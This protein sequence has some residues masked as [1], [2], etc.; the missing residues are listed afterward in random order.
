MSGGPTQVEGPA[1]PEPESGP[2]LPEWSWTA[3]SGAPV[4]TTAPS[5]EWDVAGTPPGAPPAAPSPE[6]DVSVGEPA[7]GRATGPRSKPAGGSGWEAAAAPEPP[8]RAMEPP[9]DGTAERIVQ[10]TPPMKPEGVSGRIRNGQYYAYDWGFEQQQYYERLA[11]QIITFMISDS[12]LAA[13]SARFIL[14]R[15]AGVDRGQRRELEY[16]LKPHFPSMQ[17]TL[18]FDDLER[19]LDIVYDELIG[20]GPLGTAWRDDEVTEIMVDG[21]N[22][23]YVEH[24]GQLIISTAKFRSPE[25]ANQIARNL[26]QMVSDRSLSP[27]NPLVTAELDG[28]RVNFAYAPVVKSGLAITL[29]KFMP[30]MGMQSLLTIGSLSEDMA[31]F[32]RDAVVARSTLLVSGGTGVGKTTLINALS[33]FIPN[34][35]RVITI[36]DA[37]ELKLANLFVLPLQTK[38][39]AS[40]D[41]DVILTQEDLLVNT[42]RMRPDRIVVGEIRDARAAT[43][44]L[45]AANTG[46]D[47]TMTTIHA[48]SA[49]AALNGRLASLIR[50]GSGVSDDIAK[51]QIAEA[52]DVVLQGTRRRGRRFVEEIAEVG[53]EGFT[54][55]LIKPRPIFRAAQ[56]PDGGVSFTRVGGIDPRGSLAEKMR[57]AGI[58]PARWEA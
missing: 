6:G 26:A 48:N 4:S 22:R 36:E 16:E 15:D 19:V 18:A 21:W 27:T 10:P 11:D 40:R 53:T 3:P 45:Q 30:L 2:E 38:E 31:S 58:D 8:G 5:P 13:L 43:V 34:S 24:R 12:Q 39:R 29:R 14:T 1:R 20:L 44:M 56:S 55:S 7:Q 33:E 46:H 23:V 42:L 52:F 51:Y 47:G 17:L 57:E 41:D 54:G 35:E 9:A 49:D 50:T 28:A 25:H 32:L 37:Y